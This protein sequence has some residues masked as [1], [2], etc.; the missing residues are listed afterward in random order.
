MF[1]GQRC[2]FG[3]IYL[4]LSNE[5]FLLPRPVENYLSFIEDACWHVGGPL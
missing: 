4:T 2:A 5:V 1:A 3:S